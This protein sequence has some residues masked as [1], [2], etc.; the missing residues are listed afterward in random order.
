MDC[1]GSQFSLH[2]TVYIQLVFNCP[3]FTVYAKGIVHTQHILLGSQKFTHFN[4]C[5]IY[6]YTV[7]SNILQCMLHV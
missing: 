6:M 7:Y 5:H 4:L 1:L 3:L 2:I